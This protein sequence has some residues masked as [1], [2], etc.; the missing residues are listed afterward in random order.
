MQILFVEDD[1]GIVTALKRFFKYF[2]QFNMQWAHT[3]KEGEVLLRQHNFDVV[4]ADL[5][6]EFP[7]DGMALLSWA[8]HFQ[9]KAVRVLTSGMQQPRDFIC[10]QRQ[11]YLG[12][13]FEPTDLVTLLESVQ[14]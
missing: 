5:E 8:E 3:A 14:A 9:P 11:H 1:T 6:L 2:P 4:V 13:P 10:G 7:G 12:K